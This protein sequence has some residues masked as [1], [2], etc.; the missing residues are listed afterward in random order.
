MYS[1]TT[2]RVLEMKQKQEYPKTIEVPVENLQMDAAMESELISKTTT[3]IVNLDHT[4]EFHDCMNTYKIGNGVNSFDMIALGIAFYECT[5][6]IHLV[7][8]KSSAHITGNT[9]ANNTWDV[10]F[11][12]HLVITMVWDC[13]TWKNVILYIMVNGYTSGTIAKGGRKLKK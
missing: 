12:F 3:K 10:I 4:N 2:T 5:C 11:I 8:T 9:V 7:T 13:C 6:N 1:M